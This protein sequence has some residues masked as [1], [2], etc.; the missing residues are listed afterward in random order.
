MGRATGR[1]Y[2]AALKSQGYIPTFYVNKAEAA[3][4]SVMGHAHGA[5]WATMYPEGHYFWPYYDWQMCMDHQPWRDYLAQTCARI[6]EETGG[7][8]DLSQQKASPYLCPL[9]SL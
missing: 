5:D 7:V 6:I 1:K 9:A 2:V 8:A 4:G 3:F